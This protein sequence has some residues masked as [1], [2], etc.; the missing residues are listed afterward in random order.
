M[1]KHDMKILDILTNKV[2]RVVKS[3]Y[4]KD[5]PLWSIDRNPKF[6]SPMLSYNDAKIFLLTRINNI[7]P[8][9]KGYFF[10]V[11]HYRTPSISCDDCGTH[12]LKA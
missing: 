3:K 12:V 7:K 8:C 9:D 10:Y 1:K 4:S 2:Y 5:K 11:A 6:I